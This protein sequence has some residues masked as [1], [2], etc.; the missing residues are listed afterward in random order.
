MHSPWES[1]K[2]CTLMDDDVAGPEPYKSGGCGVW[3]VQSMALLS[4]ASESV[5][6]KFD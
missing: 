2:L 6:I 1:W 4:E 5:N 3:C